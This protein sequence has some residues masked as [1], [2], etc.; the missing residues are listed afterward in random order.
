MRPGIV[1][2]EVVGTVPEDN[3]VSPGQHDDFTF[4][5]RR[6]SDVCQ[7]RHSLAS[8]ATQELLRLAPLRLQIQVPVKAQPMYKGSPSRHALPPRLIWL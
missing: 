8:S 4:V 3:S 6:W 7:D 5:I 2:I 1:A